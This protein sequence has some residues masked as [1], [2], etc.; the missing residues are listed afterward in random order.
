LTELEQ[1]ISEIEG[2]DTDVDV[3]EGKV[4]R[5]AFLVKF[6][7]TKLRN[8][9]DEVKKVLAEIEADSAEGSVPAE[10]DK[11]AVE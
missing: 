2:E 11:P 1:I 4:K 6:C 3:L 5:A 10:E 7:R 9:E 8:A